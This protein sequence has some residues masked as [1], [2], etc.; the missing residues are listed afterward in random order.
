[1]REGIKLSFTQR[2]LKRCLFK[3]TASKGGLNAFHP[4]ATQMCVWCCMDTHIPQHRR[5]RSP[6]TAGLQNKPT[7]LK[8]CTTFLPQS[9]SRSS[10]V[11]IPTSCKEELERKPS[12]EV[13]RQLMTCVSKCPYDHC[14]GLGTFLCLCLCPHGVSAISF[15][16][17]GRTMLTLS[18]KGTGLCDSPKVWKWITR[19]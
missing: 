7:V 11:Q 4:K 6:G 14:H 15:C 19:I 16:L 3:D 13:L 1:M 2:C 18:A 17:T 5:L 9:L 10:A 8:G 12:L